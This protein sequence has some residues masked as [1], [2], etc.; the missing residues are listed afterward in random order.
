MH[1]SSHSSNNPKHHSSD[2]FVVAVTA[3]IKLRLRRTFVRLGIVFDLAL[4]GNKL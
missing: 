4:I 2:N 1:I 3:A